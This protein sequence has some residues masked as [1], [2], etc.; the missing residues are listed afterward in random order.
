[1]TVSFLIATIGRA[2]LAATLQSI[3]CWPGDEILVIG[4]NIRV[5]DVRVRS[6]HCR[7]GGNFGHA[8]RNFAMPQARAQYLAH[9]DDDDVYVPGARALMADA[10][11]TT[12]DVPVMFRMQY[13]NEDYLWKVPEL[14]FGNVGTPMSLL[15]NQ[16]EKLGKFGRRVGGD[17]EFLRTSTWPVESFVWRPDVTV[18]LGHN[19]GE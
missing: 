8:E 12:P 14:K 2:S 7:P 5:T 9:I 19:H 16:P 11:T 17:Y 3:E 18:R 10:M 13:P 15:P 4:Y 6:L 1:M